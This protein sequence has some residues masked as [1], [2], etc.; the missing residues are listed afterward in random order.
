MSV[1]AAPL[2]RTVFWQPVEGAGLEHLRL[3]AVDAGYVAAGTVMG[4]AGDTPYRLH[5]KIKCDDS[6]N[7]RKVTLEVHTPAG[8]A[9]R[10]LRSNGLG[11]WRDDSGAEMPELNGCRDVD[12]SAT[13]FTNTL[14]IRRANLQPGQGVTLKIVYVNVP[15][16]AIRPAEQRYSCIER[17]AH[18]GVY[19]YE[20]IDMHDG[21]K[22]ILP[23]DAD[24]L[25]L[26]YPELFKRVW[27]R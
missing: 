6:W 15:G 1:A 8:E 21:F 11:R 27:P 24:G 12:I 26:D 7:T 20:S 19:G 5:Y 13:P 9:V 23:V 4:I 17:T 18:G 10:T 14:A 2:R 25:V 16:L 22:A 3:R